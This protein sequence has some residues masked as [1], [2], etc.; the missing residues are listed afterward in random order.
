MFQRPNKLSFQ[1]PEL[2]HR[3]F[4]KAE[5]CLLAFKQAFMNYVMVGDKG[6]YIFRDVR[7]CA[8]LIE[9]RK[10]SPRWELVQSWGF[11]GVPEVS[12]SEAGSSSATVEFG[13]LSFNLI[14]EFEVTTYVDVHEDIR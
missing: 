7:D 3:K 1:I 9:I 14:G 2:I 4:G 12:V 8:Y 10:F 11:F 13:E 6:D 5:T